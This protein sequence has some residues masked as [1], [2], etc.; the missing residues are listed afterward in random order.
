MSNT[1]S[2]RAMLVTLNVSQ[3]TARKLDKRETEELARKHGTLTDIARVNKS[4]LPF[5]SSLEKIH[6]ATGSIRTYYYAQ[7]LPWGQEGSRIIPSANYMSFVAEMRNMIS[8][9]N[10]LVSNFIADYPRLKEEARVL[11]NG[12]YREEDY[13]DTL[14]VERKFRADVSFFPVPDARDFRVQLADDELLR[15]QSEM[16]DRVME[17]QG[18]A[19]RECWD[20]LYTIVKHAK[21]KL[22]DP[23]GIF[24]DSM[25]DNAR[26]LCALLPKLNIAGDANLERMRSEVEGALCGHSADTLRTAPDVR[27]SAAKAMSDIMAKMGSFYA[28]A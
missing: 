23:K 25:I 11:L 4:L 20:R 5:A 7:T 2:D 15:I 16:Q 27:E 14:D 3:W 19:M 21:E 8:A 12:L 13:P 24:R 26:E 10:K 22:S 28:A 1:L 18:V 9:W 6:K 17:A